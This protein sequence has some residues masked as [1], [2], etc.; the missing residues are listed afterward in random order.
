MMTRQRLALLVYSAVVFVAGVAA[1]ELWTGPAA[2][3]AQAAPR[4]FELRTYTAPD[5]KL[6]ELHRRFRDHTLR[7]F[8][9]HG[10]TNVVYLS[11]QDPPLSSNTL[12]Y[13]LAHQSREAAKQSWSAFVNDPEWKKVSSESQVNGKI[14]ASVTT[15]FLD[16]TDYSPMK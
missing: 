6:A 15:M 7:I 10:M 3:N 14:V 2:A 11:P 12:V 1:G 9:K 13:L 8:T 5:G 16:P 4:V